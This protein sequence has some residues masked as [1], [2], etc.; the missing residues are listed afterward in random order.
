MS[1][2][3]VVPNAPDGVKLPLLPSHWQWVTLDQLLLRIEAGKSFRCEERPPIDGEYGVV[4][5]SA[6][7]WGT[8]DEEESKTITDA[9]RID[10][11]YL[12]RPGDFLFSRANTMQL[13]GASVIVHETSKRLL[14]SD[15]ILR[16]VFAADF[17]KWLN[18]LFKSNIGRSQIEALSTGN[19]ESMRNIGQR[20]IGQICVPIA[21]TKEMNRIISK[22]DELF[23]RID[24]GERALARVQKLVE[25]YRQSVLKAAVTGELTRDWREKNKGKL[26]SGEALRAQI[27]RARRDAWEM[28]EL[29]KWKAEGVTPA[30]DKWKQK[31]DEPVSA[32]LGLSDIVPES[33]TELSLE[34]A[35]KAERPIAYG[36]LQPGMDVADGVLMVRVCDVAEG[37]VDLSSLR[38]ISP[39]I[40]GQFPRTKLRGGEVLLTLVGTIGRTA[41]VPMEL[42]GANVARAVGVL[43]PMRQVLAEWL[44]LCLRHEKTRQVLTEN[45]REVA[46]KTLN[47]EQ[48]REYAVPCPSEAEQREAVSR[49]NE[50]LSKAEAAAQAIVSQTRYASAL[51]Q[52]TLKAAFRGELVAHDPADEPAAVLLSRI[53]ADR[54][55][56]RTTQWRG[57]KIKTQQPA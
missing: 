53:A 28:A 13:V 8:Y 57:R 12:I 27:L 30:N 2:P 23:S 37:V 24:E 45:A 9:E 36:V 39:A 52:S 5:V 50:L 42:A 26:E 11:T 35:T 22:I 41:I 6:V 15:K 19:Q 10:E 25:R 51:R 56:P 16:F 38:R 34:Q 29:D 20:R 17:R 49:S 1:D 21:P 31:Y 55:A 44:E 32:R 48:L 14:L 46:R 47:L 7:T 40:A 4:K 3:G 18:W 33:W 43:A 54:S